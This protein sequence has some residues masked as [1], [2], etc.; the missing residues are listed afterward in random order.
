MRATDIG[1]TAKDLFHSMSNALKHFW[2]MYLNGGHEDDWAFAR[3]SRDVIDINTKMPI[4][5]PVMRKAIDGRWVYR[6]MTEFEREE[7]DN[8]RAW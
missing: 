4:T 7:F 1:E 2:M 8:N 5:G 6:E 3:I